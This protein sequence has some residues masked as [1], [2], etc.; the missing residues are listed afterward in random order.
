MFRLG[1]GATLGI[2]TKNIIITLSKG[3]LMNR[4]NLLR[5][6]IVTTAAVSMFGCS[7]DNLSPV[8]VSSNQNSKVALVGGYGAR[9]IGAGGGELW[10][11]STEKAFPNQPLNNNCILY[12]YTGSSWQRY[13]SHYG[14]RGA[15]GTDGRF[16]H[17]NQEGGI[18]W[19]NAADQNGNIPNPTV[20]GVNVSPVDIGV[21]DVGGTQYVWII[22]EYYVNG[23]WIPRV[24]RYD[25]VSWVD[26]GLSNTNDPYRISVELNNGNKAWVVGWSNS[27]WRCLW[28]YC[29]SRGWVDQ[30]SYV[31]SY[32]DACDFT[33]GKYGMKY[34]ISGSGNYQVYGSNSYCPR[35]GYNPLNYYAR[36]SNWA[37]GG[38]CGEKDYNDDARCYVIGTG[39]QVMMLRDY[40]GAWVELP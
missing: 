15:V 38:I 26:M 21:G 9:D 13:G 23:I 5:T 14:L 28:R 30:S 3:E 6:I 35:S 4:R 8:S 10:V 36:I 18:W 37:G 34:F 22:G 17:I 12:R 31:N 39:G 2:R 20:N 7:N 1:V 24:Y 25:G 19:V 33:T 32:G 40:D 29:S 27:G 16:Y 11:V